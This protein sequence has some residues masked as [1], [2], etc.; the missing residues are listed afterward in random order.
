MKPAAPITDWDLYRKR[1]RLKKND[2][3]FICRGYHTF[4]RALIKRG[5]HENPDFDSP[6][7]HLKFTVKAKDVFKM[8]KGT[9]QNMKGDDFADTLKDFQMV[10]HFYKHSFITS[11]IGLTESLKNLHFYE[12]SLPAE[13]FYPKCFIL[14]RACTYK[15]KEQL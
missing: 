2:K 13:E 15:T 14:N 3:I 7:F 10:N 4:K 11:K 6:I 12:N 5:W 8:Q 9:I 1:N